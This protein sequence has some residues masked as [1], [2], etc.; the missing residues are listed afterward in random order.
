MGSAADAAVLRGT[1]EPMP[2]AYT[3][4]YFRFRANA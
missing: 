2:E 1:A 4:K 3:V